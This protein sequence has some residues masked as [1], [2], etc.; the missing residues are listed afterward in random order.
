[1]PL[2]EE[3]SSHSQLERRRQNENDELVEQTQA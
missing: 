1:M 2:L 3:A